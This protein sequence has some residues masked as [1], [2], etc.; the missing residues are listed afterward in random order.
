[1]NKSTI[2]LYQRIIP[3]YRIKIFTKL[4]SILGIIVCASD[5]K[6]KFN[7]KSY[8]NQN[9]KIYYKLKTM[10]L[11]FGESTYIQRVINSLNRF[12]PTIVI[13]E[14]AVGYITFYKLFLLKYFYGYKIIVWT[15]GYTQLNGTIIPILKNLVKKI[16][17]LS[18][19][20]IIF[21]SHRAKK[22]I[23]KEVNPAKL[24]VACNTLD[25]K[26]MIQ[27]YFKQLLIGRDN[28]KKKLNFNSKFNL[29]YIGR[30][31]PPKNI[32]Y[33]LKIY[34][35]LSSKMDIS[36]H[37]I[38]EGPE[39]IL[40]EEQQSKSTGIYYYGEIIDEHIVGEYLFASDLLINPGYIGL[41]IMHAFCFGKPV[42]TFEGNSLFQIS[43]SPEIE[44]LIHDYNGLILSNDLGLA[45][46]I[47]NKLLRNKNKLDYLSNNALNTAKK[48]N[49]DNFING[50][51][52]AIKYVKNESK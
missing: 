42:V 5:E 1:M 20:A 4:N 25:T 10:K 27:I 17:Y 50:F 3:H 48:Y 13:S 40:V 51:K 32:N 11:P 30:L 46:E 34:N 38:G 29:I 28:I 14:F 18:C 52:D 16:V 43:H 35:M 49:L 21:Y 44:Y 8:I 45:C 41:S 47:I 9:D 31:I 33:L 7:L 22:I 36:L 26:S 24:F 39:K 15:H 23:E 19:D 12:K 6:E 2:L 37:I